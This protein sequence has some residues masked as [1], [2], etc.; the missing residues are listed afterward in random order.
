VNS[1]KVNNLIGLMNKS[2]FFFA[3]L[4]TVM[5]FQT[6]AQQ[7]GILPKPSPAPKSWMPLIGEYASASDTLYIA[8]DYA[9]LLLVTKKPQRFPLNSISGLQYSFPGGDV[10]H[11]SVVV[12]KRSAAGMVS[13]FRVGAMS[14][15]RLMLGAEHESSFS[16][17]PLKPIAELRKIALAA[18]PPVENGEFLPA[19][20]VE[21]SSLDP[22]IKYDIRY[23]TTNN[24]LGEPVYS[25]AKA[26]LQRPAAMALV[27]AQRWLKERGYGLLIHDAYRPWY[28]T[29][30]FWD[31]TPEDKKIFVADPSKGSRHNRGCAV[32]LSLHDLKTGKPLEMTGGYDEMSERSYPSFPGGTSLQR[33]NRDLLRN[34]ME[35]NGFA[36]YDWEWWHFDYKDW[37]KYPIGT[38]T[39][40][41]I[42]R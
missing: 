39:F 38:K 18:I 10:F 17:T 40:E 8:E 12:F 5:C 1:E 35:S 11:D 32:D 2:V 21:L 23:A 37:K 14:F 31:A 24:F 27:N 41:E 28:V 3:V 16:I 6:L 9:Q 25:Q 4:Q 19:D 34:A 33:W 42:S 13:E 26:F 30:I 20:L 29:K 36:V 7:T 15:K 22:A